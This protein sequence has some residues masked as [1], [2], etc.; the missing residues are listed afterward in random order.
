MVEHYHTPSRIQSLPEESDLPISSSYWAP[1]DIACVSDLFDEVSDIMKGIEH[2]R[3]QNHEV[4]IFQILDPWERDLPLEGNIR[5]H[6]LE[7][8]E[9]LTTQAEGIREMYLEKLNEWRES[10]EKECRNRSVDRVELT[11]DDPLDQALLDYLVKR[12]KVY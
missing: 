12:S 7:T 11:T 2:L 3:F 4:L 9:E 10:L 6:D 1:D 5:F 8:G